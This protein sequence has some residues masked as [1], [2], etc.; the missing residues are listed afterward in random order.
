MI[1]KGGT[2]E[3]FGPLCRDEEARRFLL[4][5]NPLANIKKERKKNGK[6]QKISKSDYI[7]R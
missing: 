4:D 5:E 1:N 7:A 2:A 3:L 6:G